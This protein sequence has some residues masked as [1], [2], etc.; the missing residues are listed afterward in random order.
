[1]SQQNRRVKSLWQAAMRCDELWRAVINWFTIACFFKTFIAIIA[2]SS[3]IKCWKWDP[4]NIYKIFAVILYWFGGDQSHPCEK[5][6]GNK[7]KTVSL[8]LYSD[9]LYSACDA[10]RASIKLQTPELSPKRP[11]NS[12]V[13]IGLEAK[14]FCDSNRT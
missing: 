11:W 2:S 7:T 6:T 5:N 3:T 4:P 12:P 10:T 8:Y 1:M 9:H 13:W 14:V